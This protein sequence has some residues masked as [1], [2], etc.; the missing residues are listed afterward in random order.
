MATVYFGKL[1][2][3]NKP[4]PLAIE[5][6]QGN[7]EPSRPSLIR[8]FCR[9]RVIHHM[10]NLVS[11][12]FGHI[13]VAL[14][15]PIHSYICAA[16][17]G[18]MLERARSLIPFHPLPGLAFSL[19][20][21][22][23]MA[24]INV[25]ILA[26]RSFRSIIYG[27]ETVWL[28][29]N[30]SREDF[31]WVEQ[32]VRKLSESSKVPDRYLNPIGFRTYLRLMNLTTH[33]CT[34]F[35]R[36]SENSGGKDAAELIKVSKLDGWRDI[37]SGTSAEEFMWDDAN[38]T[39]GLSSPYKLD[40][41][42][43]K[44]LTSVVAT[45]GSS[46]G[47]SIAN[48]MAFRNPFS[49]DCEGSIPAGV[50]KHITADGLIL[51]FSQK[52]AQPESQIIGDVIGRYFLTC[53]G[54]TLDDQFSLLEEFREGALAMRLLPIGDVLNHLYKCIEIAIQCHSGLVPFYSNTRYEGCVLMGGPGATIFINGDSY[55]FVSMDDLKLEY[56]ATSEHANA[57]HRISLY[58]MPSLQTQVCS[59]TSMSQL[60]KLLLVLA[61]TP[62]QR[63]EILQFA[64][65]LDYG[66]S[67]WTI[68][69]SNIKKALDII[70]GTSSVSDTDPIA[71]IALFSKDMVL[72]ALSCFGE[73]SA[74]SWD[75]PNGKKIS[76]SSENPP[77]QP[78]TSG[79]KGQKGV[80]DADWVMPVRSVDVFTAG[81]E[82]R[83][84][85]GN[86]YYRSV[87]TVVARAQ[88]C[89][90]FSR[91]QMAGFWR[92]LRVA[93]SAVN[94]NIKFGEEERLE[95]RKAAVSGD[96]GEGSNK[97]RRMDY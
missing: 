29:E 49:I 79:V 87:S 62:E 94:P 36:L 50:P 11:T 21:G 64:V 85:I 65:D 74:P 45:V 68:S 35:H 23:T 72:V 69:A 4:S 5:T 88:G 3:A 70:S 2:A 82:F 42:I 63:D 37:K 71:R 12:F 67:T 58:F 24:E 81:D 90:M 13:L 95:K 33:I 52:L 92:E 97:R 96:T 80:S 75:I 47:I 93:A 19:L 78:P 34:F 14:S 59:T 77:S 18:G 32:H 91:Q 26:E 57:L 53:L 44:L 7:L 40:G 56:S 10:Y 89:R 46:N 55:P 9:P 27:K 61:C 25:P 60:R 1:S 39:S 20:R 83:R 28:K 6:P 22:E 30:A 8:V 16:E 86:G 38:A 54:N 15:H 66:L 48:G 73:K 76:I 43:D 31:V 41:R 51:K 84:V 17:D